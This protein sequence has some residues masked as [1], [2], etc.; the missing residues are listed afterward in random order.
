MILS[1]QYVSRSKLLLFAG[2]LGILLCMSSCASKVAQSPKL[3]PMVEVRVTSERYNMQLDF[4]KHHFSGMLIVR[5]L[6]GN[7]IRI[8][9]T[10][11]FGLSLFDFSLHGETF[12]VNSCIEPMKKEKVL[13]LLEGDFKN[14]FLTSSRARVKEKSSTFEKRITGK[15]FGKSV[16]ALSEYMDGNPTRVLI[17]HPWIRLKIQ[18]DRLENTEE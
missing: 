3:P 16:Y 8:L 1:L 9:A 13:K 12:T 15:F 2:L 14:L 10:T 11:Y 4:M 6:P 17:K 5:Q 7:E 18:L